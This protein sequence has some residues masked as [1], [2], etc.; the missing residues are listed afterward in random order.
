MVVSKP[1][2]AKSVSVKIKPSRD[3][4][5]PYSFTFS[6]KVTLPS[7]VTTAK[8][9]S[10]TVTVTLKNGK[11]TVTTKKVSV[12]KDC[13]YSAKVT[14]SKKGKMKASVKFAG[15]SSV[16][17]KTSAALNLRAG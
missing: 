10:G 16:G 17:A 4:S 12:K 7:G 6:G 14:V 1:A 13:T 11:K 8:G 2:A 3:R 15:N 9:C 5:K